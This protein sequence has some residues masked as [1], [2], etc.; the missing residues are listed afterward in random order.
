MLDRIFF[1]FILKPKYN[2]SL[3]IIII[4][5]IGIII[6]TTIF[7]LTYKRLITVII[8]IFNINNK[9]QSL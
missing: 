5:I 4:N 1:S 9:G 3:K 7:F 6:M 2:I 8:L